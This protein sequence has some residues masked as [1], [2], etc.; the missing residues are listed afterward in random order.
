ML[1]Y[2]TPLRIAALLSHTLRSGQDTVSFDIVMSLKII[3]IL[4]FL[5]VLKWEDVLC[6]PN[7]QVER[8][9]GGEDGCRYEHCA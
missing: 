6:G 5:Q 3:A 9:E 1:I 7:R 4:E 8:E 2:V